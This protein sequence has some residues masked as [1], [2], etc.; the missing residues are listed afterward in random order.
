MAAVYR[1]HGIDPCLKQSFPSSPHI[2]THP[3][4]IASTPNAPHPYVVPEEIDVSR[5]DISSFSQSTLLLALKLVR[6]RQARSHS[7]QPAVLLGYATVLQQRHR[8]ADKKQ[9]TSDKH[10][11]PRRFCER[12]GHIV[13]GF[14]RRRLAGAPDFLGGR[15]ALVGDGDAQNPRRQWGEDAADGWIILVAEDAEDE[16]QF[17]SAKLFAHRSGE[18]FGAVRVV[19]AVEHEQRLAPHDVEAARPSRPGKAGPHLFGGNLQAGGA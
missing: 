10:I 5:R 6:A 19:R 8:F 15:A 11:F 1:G 9:R 4:R 16:R 18:G 14:S 3:H 17:P 13:T 2:T 7:L 12:V